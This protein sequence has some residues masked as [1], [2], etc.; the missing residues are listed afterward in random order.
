MKSYFT[1]HPIRSA[2][3]K[4]LKQMY[5]LD[6]LRSQVIN[7]LIFLQTIDILHDWQ[8]V[9]AQLSQNNGIVPT[10]KPVTMNVTQSD[11]V[12]LILSS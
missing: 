7:T 11:Y 1:N 4:I 5:A 8:N 10:I 9:F 6:G 2:E 12:E 3:G